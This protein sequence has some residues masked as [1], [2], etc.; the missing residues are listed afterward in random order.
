M[1]VNSLSRPEAAGLQVILRVVAKLVQMNSKD[2]DKVL[3]DA[4]LEET[5]YDGLDQLYHMNDQIREFRK[6]LQ[7]R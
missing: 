2:L 6:S 5:F 7:P 4:N 3:D 1:D